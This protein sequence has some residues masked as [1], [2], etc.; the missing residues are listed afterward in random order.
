MM[1]QFADVVVIIVLDTFLVCFPCD[2][3]SRFSFFLYLAGKKR[4]KMQL[5]IKDQNNRRATLLKRTNMIMKSIKKK[6]IKIRNVMESILPNI[7][8]R[9]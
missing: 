4:Y 9:K 5:T 2:F 6:E 1:F 7:M 3:C 8:E